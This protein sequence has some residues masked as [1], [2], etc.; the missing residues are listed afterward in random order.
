MAV[1]GLLD[2]MAV[3]NGDFSTST[4]VAL[5]TAC[6]RSA[7]KAIFQLVLPQVFTVGTVGEGDLRVTQS[8]GLESNRKK[9]Y[10]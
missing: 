4:L 3:Y 9:N 6:A 5:A 8:K 1:D 2:L 10:N 7:I